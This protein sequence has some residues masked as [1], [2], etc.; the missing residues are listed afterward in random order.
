MSENLSPNVVAE[1]VRRLA[2]AF[3]ILGCHFDPGNLVQP[4][5]IANML[6]GIDYDETDEVGLVIRLGL[7]KPAGDPE[8]RQ[9]EPAEMLRF[10][11]EHGE[12]WALGRLE[13]MRCELRKSVRAQ[14]QPSVASREAVTQ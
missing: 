1:I 6:G 11:E 5:D 8:G 9:V 13:A 7:L 14:P 2:Q 10:L 12:A 4:Q 3:P